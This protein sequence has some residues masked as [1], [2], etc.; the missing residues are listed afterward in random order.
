MGDGVAEWTTDAG[1][2]SAA[3]GIILQAS[4]R[5]T[6]SGE[7]CRHPPPEHG[8]YLQ[9]YSLQVTNKKSAKPKTH[10]FTNLQFLPYKPETKTANC[11]SCRAS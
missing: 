8:K 1:S 11:L 10:V 3:G 5:L 2:N 7:K 9:G 4:H 6:V